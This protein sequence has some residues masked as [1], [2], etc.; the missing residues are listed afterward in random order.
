MLQYHIWLAADTKGILSTGL[1]GHEGA[2]LGRGRW[3]D[4]VLLTGVF[5][6]VARGVSGATGKLTKVLLWKGGNGVEDEVV[7][8]EKLPK[9]RFSEA[10]WASCR[11]VIW[12]M[13]LRLRIGL[14]LGIMLIMNLL[15]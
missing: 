4:F 13:D 1:F 10:I 9:M 11:G 8:L 7:S 12:R 6:W 5:L 14:V 3:K 15:W 2:A